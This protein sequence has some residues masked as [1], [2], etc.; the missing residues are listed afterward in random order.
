[1]AFESLWRQSVWCFERVSFNPELEAVLDNHGDSLFSILKWSPET[2]NPALSQYLSALGRL[3]PLRLNA[4]SGGMSQNDKL[5]LLETVCG[6]DDVAEFLARHET[7][8]REIRQ[9][10][11]HGKLSLVRSYAIDGVIA[12]FLWQAMDLSAASTRDLAQ[13]IC[14]ETIG[15]DWDHY[16][17]VRSEPLSGE[18]FG[19]PDAFITKALCL[20]AHAPT[21]TFW[22]MT[23]EMMW[24]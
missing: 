17:A 20:V 8:L 5:R 14:H 23:C 3:D 16:L 10:G 21:T 6:M 15:E 13:K 24:D 4:V 1:M 2:P 12:D 11:L 18:A 9:D 19:C 7:L 22:L